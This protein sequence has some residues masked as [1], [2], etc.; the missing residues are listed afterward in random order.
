M[1]GPPFIDSSLEELS[2]RIHDREI[3]PVELVERCLARVQERDD[4][5]HRLVLLGG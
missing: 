4:D 3:T 5:V 1:S 2:R